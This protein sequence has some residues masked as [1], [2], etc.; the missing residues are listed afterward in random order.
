V[1]VHA[2]SQWGVEALHPDADGKL[3]V[4]VPRRE[5][6]HVVG[7]AP[8]YAFATDWVDLERTPEQ[9]AVLELE[10]IKRY[11]LDVARL[12]TPVPEREPLMV[13]AGKIWRDIEFSQKQGELQAM[14]KTCVCIMHPLGEVSAEDLSRA[15]PPPDQEPMRCFFAMRLGEGYLVRPNPEEGWVVLRLREPGVQGTPLTSKSTR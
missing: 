14:G 9:E 12:D 2:R 8:G 3:T 13:E 10:K 7:E 15:A 11:Q 1:T 4:D 6:F 5:G